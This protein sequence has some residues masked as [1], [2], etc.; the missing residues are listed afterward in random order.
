ALQVRPCQLP[1]RCGRFRHALAAPADRAQRPGA[2]RRSVRGWRVSDLFSFC[3][4][5]PDHRLRWDEMRAAYGWLR[6]LDGCPPGPFYQAEGDVGPH[7]RMVCEE[8]LALPAWRALAEEDRRVLFAAALLHD[9][10]KPECTR[11]DADGR[12][13]S[14]GHSRRSAI[15]ARGLLW[16]QRA[17]F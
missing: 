16:R 17:P 14:R 4:G 9:A 13:S 7:T 10:A 15:L 6:A 3:P 11:I 5:P 2:R 12:I 1:D 8:L